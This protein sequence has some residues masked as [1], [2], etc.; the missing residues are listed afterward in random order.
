MESKG[1]N[2]NSYRDQ[3][4]QMQVESSVSRSRQNRQIEA[5]DDDMEFEE[6]EILSG[7]Q[8]HFDLFATTELRQS[9]QMPQR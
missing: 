2:V 9:I 8:A 1:I 3:Y 5:D 7:D 4:G 6:E